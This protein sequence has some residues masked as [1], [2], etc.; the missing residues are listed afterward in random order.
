MS[1]S[2]LALAKS[3]YW[4]CVSFKDKNALLPSYHRPAWPSAKWNK[5]GVKEIT[6]SVTGEQARRLSP[7]ATKWREIWHQY[8]ESV[9]AKTFDQSEHDSRISFGCITGRK[10]PPLFLLS[11]PFIWLA[12]LQDLFSPIGVCS[13]RTLAPNFCSWATR[14]SQFFHTNHMLGTL[15][16]TGSEHWAPFNFP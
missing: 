3:I 6:P 13:S 11:Q 16:F 12:S 4:A 9:N 2:F 15:D 8:C 5:D 14:K 10:A 7:L 1:A